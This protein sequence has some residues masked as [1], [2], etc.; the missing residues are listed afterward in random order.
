MTENL[1]K[2]KR[3]ELEKLRTRNI[4]FIFL[5]FLHWNLLFLDNLLCSKKLFFTKFFSKIY[6]ARNF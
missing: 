5:T 2:G 1:V 6:F 3:G 4:S